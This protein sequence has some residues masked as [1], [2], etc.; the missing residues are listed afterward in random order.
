[1]IQ[2]VKEIAVE[3]VWSVSTDNNLGCTQF[4][5]SKFTRLVKTLILEIISP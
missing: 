4:D 5:F 2:R 3:T 1:M